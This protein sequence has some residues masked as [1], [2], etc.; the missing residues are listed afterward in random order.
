MEAARTCSRLLTP[1]IHLIS[2][3][4]VSQTAVQVVADVLSKLLV[5]GITDP[6]EACCGLDGLQEHI[7]LMCTIQA[8]SGASKE[9]RKILIIKERFLFLF[10]LRSWHPLL[11]TRIPRWAFWCTPRPGWEPAGAVCR[12]ERRSV[13]DQRVG[14][15]HDRTPQQHEPGFRHAF[16]SQDAHPGRRGSRW[17][18]EA[19]VESSTAI[20]KKILL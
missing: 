5:V 11:C 3:H 1:S 13:W 12:S 19:E 20:S 8:H 4:V 18:A 9:R 17:V 7:N 6:G 2:G 10:P 15:L 16:P 14:H